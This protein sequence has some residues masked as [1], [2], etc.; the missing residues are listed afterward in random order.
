MGKPRLSNVPR[1]LI[2][3]WNQKAGDC[4]KAT[5]SCLSL[6]QR[7]Q[8]EALSLGTDSL[9]SWEQVDCGLCGSKTWQWAPRWSEAAH[10]WLRSQ[11]PE[12]LDK[13]SKDMSFG[14][15]SAFLGRTVPSLGLPA[16]PGYSPLTSPELP[17]AQD[18][19]LHTSSPHHRYQWD[20]EPLGEALRDP[21]NL[22]VLRIR[23]FQSKSTKSGPY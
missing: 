20:E 11:T 12:M 7:L 15:P 21:E 10:A 4:R 5:V 6:R 3:G 18:L 19:C 1:P 2:K 8:G 14:F 13:P 23:K 16:Q 22:G 9:C 17:E